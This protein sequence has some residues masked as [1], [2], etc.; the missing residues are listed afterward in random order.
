MFTQLHNG[1]AI[2]LYILQPS[3]DPLIEYYARFA[4]FRGDRRVEAL[5]APEAPRPGDHIARRATSSPRLDVPFEVR[6]PV[7]SRPQR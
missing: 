5:G 6:I 4:G 2:Q 3:Y 7:G 1:P